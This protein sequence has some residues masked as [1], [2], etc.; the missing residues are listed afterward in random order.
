MTDT[1]TLVLLRHGE[2]KAN[3][4]GLVVATRRN[5]VKPEYGL[6]ETGERQARDAGAAFARKTLGRG[7]GARPARVVMLTSPFSRARATARAFALSM[8]EHGPAMGAEEDALVVEW[9]AERCF[10]EENELKDAASTYESVWAQDQSDPFTPPRGAGEG[11]ESVADVALRVAQGL[12][13]A[14]AD[15]A[16]SGATVFLVAHGDVLS[17][18]SAVL[19]ECAKDDAS[20]PLCEALKAHR[21]HGLGQAGWS[22]AWS[23]L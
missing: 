23:N 18:T 3:A 22:I 20:E 2:S 11:A 21:T 7:R 15:N 19:G 16:L 12:T 8:G 4:S 14:L 13:K 17:A 10:G 1:A 9:L 5:G 6:T